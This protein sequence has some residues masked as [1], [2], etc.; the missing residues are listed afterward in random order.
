MLNLK[1]FFDTQWKMQTKLP[2][3]NKLS[4]V[5]VPPLYEGCESYE[6]CWFYANGKSEV[7]ATYYSQ[8]M[9]TRG[10]CALLLN[11]ELD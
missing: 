4:T 5:A 2:N 3:G 9:A 10:H 6:S 7:V 8:E 11:E 1:K